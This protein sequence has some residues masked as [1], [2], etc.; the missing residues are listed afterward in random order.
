MRVGNTLHDRMS[1]SIVGPL[2][3]TALHDVTDSGK[4]LGIRLFAGLVLGAKPPVFADFPRPLTLDHQCRK[5]RGHEPG[6]MQNVRARI[7]NRSP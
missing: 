7:N 3:R 1:G 4:R 5:L 6:C 2:L